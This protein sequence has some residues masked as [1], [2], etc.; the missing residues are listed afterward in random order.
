MLMAIGV[1]FDLRTGLFK[2]SLRLGNQECSLMPY[3]HS[4]YD[5]CGV[6]NI[7]LFASDR[8]WENE[9][10]A[11]SIPAFAHRN[12]PSLQVTLPPPLLP[13]VT[14][15]LA[16]GLSGI[17]VNS[18]FHP[19]GRGEQRKRR[20]WAA[21]RL[22]LVQEKPLRSRFALDLTRGKSQRFRWG[23]D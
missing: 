10:F 13:S 20:L 21:L 6:Y 15:Q 11:N 22:A 18:R 16:Q 19:C 12:Y 14:E 4:S 3:V 9:A 7:S 5:S 23:Q 17:E 2:F 8:K 1:S